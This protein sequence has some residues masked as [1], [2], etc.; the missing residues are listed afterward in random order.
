MGKWTGDLKENGF[1]EERK[2]Q[3]Q[4]M[5]EK[6]EES[7]DNVLNSKNFSQQRTQMIV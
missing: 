3:V 2:C 4:S 7:L 5:A 6:E 1:T